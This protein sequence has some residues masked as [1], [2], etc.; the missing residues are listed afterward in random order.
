MKTLTL[1]SLLICIIL[2]CAP[3]F[4]SSQDVPN[5][6]GGFVLGSNM[7]EYPEVIESN[8]LKETIITDWR[9]FRKGIISVGVCKNPDILLKIQLKYADSSQKFFK[10]LLDEY[11]KSFGPPDEWKGDSFG[12]LHVW[13]WN[14]TDSENRRIIL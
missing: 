9:G 1:R 10:K 6:I 12:I 13:K 5:E 11:K 14:F 3:A 8:F 7:S 4:A 2:S